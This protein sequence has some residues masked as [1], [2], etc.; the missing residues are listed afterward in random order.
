MN[1]SQTISGGEAS[2]GNDSSPHHKRRKYGTQHGKPGAAV[3]STSSEIRI[4]GEIA[5]VSTGTVV[6]WT[7]VF[8]ESE[9]LEPIYLRLEDNI[10]ALQGECNNTLA[11][12]V[13][14][15]TKA[16]KDLGKEREWV[17]S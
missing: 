5:C 13:K 17:D 12:S 10:P 6:A 16:K 4:G 15:Q 9:T 11:V 3:P 8:I 2:V 1:T 7:I 14:R